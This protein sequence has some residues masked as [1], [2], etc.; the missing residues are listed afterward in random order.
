MERYFGELL[1][2]NSRWQGQFD[3]PLSKRIGCLDIAH[4]RLQF[5]AVLADWQGVY[6]V[7]GAGGVKPRGVRMAVDL[8]SGGKWP[9]LCDL[10][11]DLH[12]H[13]AR[14]AM[15]GGRHSVKLDRRLWRCAGLVGSGGYCFRIAACGINCLCGASQMR[16]RLRALLRKFRQIRTTLQLFPLG[17]NLIFQRTKRLS[18]PTAAAPRLLKQCVN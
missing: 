6:L 14:L 3:A 11:G 16:Y 1:L 4:R 13:G 9:R 8:A 7:A 2:W 17:L 18:T 10:R 12:C 5:A 15:G